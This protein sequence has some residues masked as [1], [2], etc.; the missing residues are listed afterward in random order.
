MSEDTRDLGRFTRSFFTSRPLNKISR[1]AR[2]RVSAKQALK[3]PETLLLRREMIRVDETLSRKQFIEE[4][5][6]ELG[7]TR[8]AAANAG[9]GWNPASIDFEMGQ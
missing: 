5:C 9:G 6:S 1:Y 7:H 2:C 8:S 3:P 4:M